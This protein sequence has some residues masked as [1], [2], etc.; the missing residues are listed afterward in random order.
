MLIK[1][2]VIKESFPVEKIIRDIKFNLKGLNLI[3]D[4]GNKRGNGVGKTTFLR[5][6]DLAFGAQDKKALYIDPETS[7]INETLKSYIENSKVFI[8]VIII[9]ETTKCETQLMVEL[10]PKGIR[11]INGEKLNY[12]EYKDKLNELIFSNSEKLPSFRSLI[13]KFI[14]V[15]MNGDNN[16]FLHFNDDHCNNAEYQNIYNYLF[17]FKNTEIENIILKIKEE[18]RNTENQFKMVKQSL[19]YENLNQIDAKIDVITAK[20]K[21]LESKQATYINEKIVL[22]EAKIMQ[23]RKEYSLLT[24]EC[25]KLL[26]DIKILEENIEKE[27]CEQKQVDMSGLKEFYDDVSF[28]ISNLN[29]KFE[30]L[31]A[32]NNELNK[33]QINTYNKLLKSKNEKLKIANERKESFYNNNRE[34]MFLV[35]NGSLDDYLNLQDN[36]N[37][38]QTGLGE[39]YNAKDIYTEYIRKIETANTFLEE[40]KDK[41]K[42]NQVD[43]NLKKFNAIFTNYSKRT[44]NAEYF[45]Y[46]EENGFPLRISNVD[47]SFST[48][49]RKSAIIAFDLAYLQYSKDMNIAGPK[50]VVHDVLENI[51]QNDFY[52]TIDLIKNQNFQYIA[53]I[54]RQSITM[55]DNIDEK[56]DIILK[57][58]EDKKLFLV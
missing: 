40:Q 7:S 38:Y 4:E 16:G 57:L 15:N 24:R 51:H 23:N 39:C 14:R 56:T 9:D 55:H 45:L 5:L 19:K 26:F 53:A 20:V 12:N 41:N 32:F 11:M 44:V 33:N 25:E 21:E 34:Y 49:T 29:K 54:L 6:I 58:S 47:G 46:Y 50:F 48:G 30:E 43:E 27:T 31:V 28:N 18:I 13:G 52:Q 42:I 2:L 36:L 22:D 3:V 37:N 8:E 10:F 35:E 1:R 17:K